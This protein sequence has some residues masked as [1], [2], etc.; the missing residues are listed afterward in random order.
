VT[1]LFGLLEALDNLFWFPSDGASVPRGP[2]KPH[3]L[4]AQIA[5]M[6]ICLVLV[7]GAVTYVALTFA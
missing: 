7:V 2:K 1:F 3:V 6:A 5:T 4:A